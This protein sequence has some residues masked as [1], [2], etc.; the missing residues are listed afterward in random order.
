MKLIQNEFLKL[1]AKK[2]IYFFT[3]FLVLFSAFLL[4]VAKKWLPPKMG[5]DHPLD[6]A[7]LVVDG[8]M[9]FIVI[10]GIVLA[11]KTLTEEFQKGTIKQLLIRPKKRIAVL[12]SKYIVTLLTVVGIIAFLAAVALL[13][14]VIGFHGGTADLTFSTFIK[15]IVYHL[16]MMF[17]YATFAFL[18]GTLFRSSVL[19]LVASI[20][21]LF[22]Q[23]MITLLIGR[24]AWSK[25]VV[26]L[27]LN[28]SMY[29]SKLNGGMEP[30]VKGFTLTTSLLLICAYIAVFLLIS[31]TVFKKKDIL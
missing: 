20:F 4:L 16:P 5:I 23:N 11:S 24:Y 6:F 27:H 3:G 30:L 9:N 21:L 22:S 1:H 12:L 10:F 15:S 29:D 17:F 18:L 8:S 2:T 28:L 14:G 19:P 13:M 26:T 31:S 7:S 25:Y